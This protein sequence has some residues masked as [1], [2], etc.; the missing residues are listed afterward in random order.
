MA[1]PVGASGRTTTRPG[2]PR[3]GGARRITPRIIRQAKAQ[4]PPYLQYI[5]YGQGGYGQSGGGGG[6]G[7]GGGSRGGGGGGGYGGGGGGGSSGPSAWEKFQIEEEKRKQRELAARKKAL[8][9]SLQGARK[10]AIPLLQRYFKQ[11]GKD[12]SGI[13]KQNQ[14]LNKGYANQLSG[15]Q[16]Q[17]TGGMNTQQAALSRDVAAQGGGGADLQA[18]LAAATQANAGTNWLAQA[19]QMYNTQLAQA[20]AMSQADAKSM[21]AGVR[22]SSLGNLENSYANLLG[23]IGLIGLQ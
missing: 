1:I 10:Q 19:G 7:G 16:K 20:M 21:G 23:Q 17:M 15:V 22:A 18:I 14:G 11:Y 5:P 6:W 2:N 9:R 8:T 13:Y 3:S 12:I 4:N